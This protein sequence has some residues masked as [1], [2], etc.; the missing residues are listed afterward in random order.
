MLL[1]V[2]PHVFNIVSKSLIRNTKH[3]YDMQTTKVMGIGLPKTGTTS[4]HKAFIKLGYRSN[5][6]LLD[7]NIMRKIR[8]RNFQIMDAF[9][10]A[11]DVPISVFWKELYA[12]YPTAQYILTPRRKER[13]LKSIANNTLSVNRNNA[14]GMFCRAMLFGEQHKASFNKEA[15][16]HTYDQHTANILSFPNFSSNNLLVFDVCGGDN[17]IKLCSFLEKPIP[18]TP[19]P[20]ENDK[21][22]N[23][24]I[25]YR[26]TDRIKLL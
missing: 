26:N 24:K 12:A 21:R 25:E 11:C 23:D 19:F 20:H 22:Y 7:Q 8:N 15:Y 18:Q 2:F 3:I 17:W 6:E 9:D 1:F 16:S 14:P 10:A 4:L 13:W 5:H